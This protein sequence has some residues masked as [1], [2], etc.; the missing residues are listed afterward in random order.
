MG[1]CLFNNV[2]LAA[3]DLASRGK[4][5]AIV[6]LDV[7]HGNGTQD[8]FWERGDVLFVSMHGS[9]LYPGTGA[10]EE[11]GAHQGIG[12]TLNLPVP[13]NTGHEGWMDVFARAALPKVRHFAPDVILVSA[14]FDAHKNDPIGNCLLVAQSYHACV[15][16]LR[17][18]QP[19]IA[20][21]LEGGYDL[22]ALGMGAAATAAALAGQPCPVTEEAPAGER[23]W[24]SLEARVLAA[25]PDLA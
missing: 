3:Q 4:R 23:P 8:I 5:V 18:A 20:A 24:A 21:V 1:F 14:G 11:R 13:A 22:E 9:P 10:V 7:H 25:H 15:A 19:R 2:A 12:A 16:A 6:D 17:E